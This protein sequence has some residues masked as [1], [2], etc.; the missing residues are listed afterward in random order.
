MT[1]EFIQRFSFASL[2]FAPGGGEFLSHFRGQFQ[3][4]VGIAPVLQPP[5]Q[6][7]LFGVRQPH[8]LRFDLFHLAYAAYPIADRGSAQG[9][10]P[11]STIVH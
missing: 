10:F 2:E 3:A 9:D 4:G 5:G 11:L 7:R 8:D 1:E 6:L